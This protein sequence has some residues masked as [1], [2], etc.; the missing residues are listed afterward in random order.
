MRPPA[1]LFHSGLQKL[2]ERTEEEGTTFPELQ[3]V[4]FIDFKFILS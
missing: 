4:I 3:Q 1:Q 2:I